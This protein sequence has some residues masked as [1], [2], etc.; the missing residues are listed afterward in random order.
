LGLLAL[1]ALPFARFDDD[2]LNLRDPNSD[3]VSA[4]NDLFDDPRVQPYSADVLA[5]DLAQA[6]VLAGKLARL[7]EVEAAITPDDFLPTGQVE[8]LAIVEEM[9]F[10]LAPLFQGGGGGGSGDEAAPPNET[11]R[12]AALDSLS[13]SLRRAQG[14]LAGPAGRLIAALDA[15]N[16][17]SA[18]NPAALDALEQALLSGLRARLDDLGEALNA[19]PVG[20]E[21]LPA[22]LR[23]RHLAADGRVR[24]EVVPR[25]DLRGPGA[26]RAFVEAVTAVAPNASG[27]PITIA[28]AGRAVVRAFLEAAV[29]ALAAISILLYAVLRSLRDSAL[30][31]APLLLAALLTIAATVILGVPFNFANVIVLPLL[32]GLG[33]AGGIHVVARARESGPGGLSATSTPRAV[34]L[35]A[36]TTIAS[37][38]ALSASGHRGTASMGVLLTIAITFSLAT[39]LILLP[40]LLGLAGARARAARHA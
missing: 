34:V 7:K 13:R 28:E 32:F 36:L 1:A 38:G 17:A 8:K 10:F 16:D 19:G 4:L 3:S 35:S 21:D 2:P 30:V 22:P 9:S 31:L 6:R 40:A 33:V 14:E 18:A 39:T 12:R 24:I 23:A 29:L 27:S 37:F 25:A 15:V 20:L 11:D 5:P 26:R